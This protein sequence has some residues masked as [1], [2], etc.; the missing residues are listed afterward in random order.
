[1]LKQRIL[2]RIHQTSRTVHRMVASS[3][4]A[5]IPEP[6]PAY[7]WHRKPERSLPV[8]NRRRKRIDEMPYDTH[9]PTKKRQEL[10]DHASNL[11]TMSVAHKGRMREAE[12]MPTHPRFNDGSVRPQVD[13]SIGSTQAGSDMS[14]S[15]LG[16]QN[17]VHSVRGRYHWTQK[18]PHPTNL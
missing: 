2:E 17:S 15:T 1:M 11:L 12:E 7:E 6:P 9:L 5:H 10:D 16:A 13:L 4:E 18:M 8:H 14:E 3:V